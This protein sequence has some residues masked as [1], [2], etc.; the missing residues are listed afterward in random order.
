M[1]DYLAVFR[2]LQNTDGLKESL[3]ICLYQLLQCYLIV[4]SFLSAREYFKQDLMAT[5]K[6]SNWDLEIV[7]K[8]M[9]MR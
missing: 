8:K 2:V 9:T 5:I 6:E 1:V 4:F 3:N 7:D